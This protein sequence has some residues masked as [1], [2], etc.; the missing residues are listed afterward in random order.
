MMQYINMDKGVMEMLVTLKE[1]LEIAEKKKIAIGSFNASGLEA[2]EAELAA[3][4]E[5]Q[6]PIIIQFAQCHES[7]G[8]IGYDRTNYGTYGKKG[9]HTGLCT[10]RSWRNTGISGKGT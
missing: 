8:T 4:E 9:K 6:L 7:M 10:F 3:A 5:L 2:I 1:I